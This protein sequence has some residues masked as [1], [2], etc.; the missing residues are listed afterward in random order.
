MTA[1]LSLPQAVT[2]SFS[3][4]AMKLFSHKPLFA[5]LTELRGDRSVGEG[6]W[7]KLCR[8][9]FGLQ[10]DLDEDGYTLYQHPVS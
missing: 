6:H 7:H 9:N 8:W 4:D 5:E 10:E 3:S 1:L 2:K